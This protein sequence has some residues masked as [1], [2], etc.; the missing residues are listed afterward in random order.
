M[1]ESSKQVSLFCRLNLNTRRDLPIRS[2]EMGMLIY[3]VKTD[4]V[5]TP[6]AAAQFFHVTKAMAT[7]MA[8]SLSSKGYI[9]KRQLKTDRRSYEPVSYTHLDVYKRQFK[10]SKI[11]MT[12]RNMMA[13][14]AS[15]S[16]SPPL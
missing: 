3:L 8:T 14:A 15:S 9:E 4:E 11:P 12:Q 5:K 1:I 10:Y 16:R 6:H 2:S 7:N 13:M